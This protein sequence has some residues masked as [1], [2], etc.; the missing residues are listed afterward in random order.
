MRHL[1]L[2]SGGRRRTGEGR[3]EGGRK[4]HNPQSIGSPM[5]AT[6]GGGEE[7]IICGVKIGRIIESVHLT[8]VETV[9]ERP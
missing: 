6:L 2:M 7:H 5:P 1:F 4:R 9:R 3:K 8:R